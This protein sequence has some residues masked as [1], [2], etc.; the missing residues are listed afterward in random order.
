MPVP[1]RGRGRTRGR[2]SHR[3]LYDP[4]NPQKHHNTLNFHED[5]TGSPDSPYSPQCQQEAHGFQRFPHDHWYTQQEY[6][7]AGSPHAEGHKHIELQEGGHLPDDTY[8]RDPYYHSGYEQ[9]A[10]SPTGRLS[11]A[12]TILR[13]VAPRESQLGNLVSRRMAGAEGFARMMAIRREVQ[14]LYS[15]VIL[16]D[17]DLC[18]HQNVEQLLWKNAF[19]QI[20]E[21]LRKQLEDDNEDSLPAKESL[22]QLIDDGTAFYQKLLDDL[23]SVYKFNLDDFLDQNSLPSENLNRKVKLA[24]LS[25]QRTLICLGDIARY[26]ELANHT[27]NYG[28][29]RSWYM[30]AQQIA[31]KNGRPYNQL[32]ILALYT[33]RK[34]DAVYYYIRSLAASNPFLTARES[35][36]SLFDEARRKAEAAEKK[37]R[38]EKAEKRK[39]RQLLKKQDAEYGTEHRLEVWHSPDGS[40]S[41]EGNSEDE[42]EL[43]ALSMIELNR[44]FILSFLNVHGKLFTKTGMESFL[45][46]RHQMLL[47][48][49]RLLSFS[50]IPVG[51][52]RLLQ[53]M[54]I[55]MFAVDNATPEEGS[56]ESDCR[57]LLQEQAVQLGLDMFACLINR[58]IVLFDEHQKS[59]NCQIL[60]EDLHQLIASIKAWADWMTCHEHLWNPPP[61]PVDPA[62]SLG[63][64]VWQSI[65]T[66]CNVLQDLQISHVKLYSS[67]REGCEAVILE[68]D[69]LMQGFV[70]LLTLPQTQTYVHSFTD[71]DVAKDCLRVIKL[72]TFGDY[73]CGIANP[74]LTYNV[75]KKS[76]ESLVSTDDEA[77]EKRKKKRPRSFTSEDDDVVVES[78]SASDDSDVGSDD[79]RS[80]KKRKQELKR[81]MK[82]KDKYQTTIE[83]ALNSQHRPL[84]IDVTPVN[85]VPDTNCFISHLDELQTIVSTSRYTLVVPLIVI[86]ELDGLAKGHRD[87]RV[88][89]HQLPGHASRAVSFL[90]EEFEAR[91]SYLKAITSKGTFMSTISFRSE[92]SAADK[93]N[94][95]DIILSC[96]LHQI[97]DRARDF[98][99]DKDQGGPITLTR[100]VVLLTDDRNLHLKAHMRNV[101]VRNVNNFMRW[102]KI[103]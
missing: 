65:A 79:I 26:R 54:A 92:E 45:E 18:N 20:I 71:K 32:A 83:A 7:V 75:P 33:R 13:E 58:S 90:E 62:Y 97:K 74:V 43:S 87:G 23:Q 68:E 94:N 61:S 47:E 53:L 49:I 12:Q 72:T 99:P 25:A 102:A 76:Y 88:D 29:S 84:V 98:M 31:P 16:L 55:N 8:T 3:T 14:N 11:K 51:N 28:R 34:L 6:T 30:K 10:S 36:M 69:V 81:K 59:G 103:S 101:P 64:D 21:M 60:S 9:E 73:L 70:P 57:A 17:P 66:F 86:T 95:D 44:R 82:Q 96:C 37:R 19:Y 41:L 1:A 52:T 27:T 48:L 42:E 40:T 5:Q 77:E 50:P 85:L 35:L 80:L 46:V 4:N 63:L 22:L 100:N 24:L 93:G 39:R 2:G 56:V 38:E 15:Q 89:C 91:N 67:M 78:S